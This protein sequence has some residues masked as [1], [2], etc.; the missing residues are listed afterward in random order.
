[1]LKSL[2]VA[3]GPHATKSHRGVSWLVLSDR[4]MSDLHDSNGVVIEYSWDVFGW[5]FVGC[6]ADEQTRL[7]NGTVTNHHTSV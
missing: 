4:Q 2:A 5:E 1:M 7:S 3:H 6:V